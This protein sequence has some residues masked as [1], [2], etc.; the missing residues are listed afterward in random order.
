M[1]TTKEQR[2]AVEDAIAAQE[3]DEREQGEREGEAQ[4][5]LEEEMKRVYGVETDEELAD[6]EDADSFR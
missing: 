2:K 1:G 6:A 4:R 3:R 5:E